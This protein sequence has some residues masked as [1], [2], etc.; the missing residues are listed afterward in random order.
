[1]LVISL[2]LHPQFV[3]E[4]PFCDFFKGIDR[5]FF[6][7]DQVVFLCDADEVEISLEVGDALD[8]LEIEVSLNLVPIFLPMIFD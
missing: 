7:K 6:P 2:L 8:R 4:S 5:I 3:L 1:L